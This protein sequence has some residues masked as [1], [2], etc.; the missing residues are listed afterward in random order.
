[1][2][3]AK[4]GLISSIPINYLPAVATEGLPNRQSIIFAAGRW[5][6]ILFVQLK[7]DNLRL[8]VLFNNVGVVEGWDITKTQIP[9]ETI[10]QK[11]NTNFTGPILLI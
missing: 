1:M 11:I 2:I 10:A 8:Y 6:D 3:Y 5:I 9:G 7:K 4:V